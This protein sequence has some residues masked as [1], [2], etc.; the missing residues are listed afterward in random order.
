VRAASRPA[1]GGRSGERRDVVVDI[2]GRVGQ[3]DRR[4]E[5]EDPQAGP[6]ALCDRP[7]D[8]SE[9]GERCQLDG[10]EA[11]PGPEAA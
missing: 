5:H 4:G 2:T 3:V 10:P 6:R 1:G 9:W 7:A 8:H 11:D